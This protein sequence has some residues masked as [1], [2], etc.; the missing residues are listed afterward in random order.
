MG[1]HEARSWRERLVAHR[2]LA[3]SFPENTLA[4]VRGALE[5]GA[6]RVEIDVQLTEDQVPIVFHDA[7]LQR[8]CGVGGSVL[9]S[10]WSQLQKLRASEPGRFGTRF[11]DE[12]IAHL[13]DFAALVASFGAHA[14]VE[15]KGESLARFGDEA[16]LAAI[17]APLEQ[18]A[19]QCT[20]ISFEL[21]V[22]GLARERLPHPVG[23]VLK[24]WSDLERPELVQLEPEVVFVD[25]LKLPPGPVQALAPLCVYEVQLA[26][27]ARELVERG[28]ALIETFHVERL[29]AELE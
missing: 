16:M 26:Q 7:T 22:L 27:R 11:A 17:R 12:P 13:A 6:R 23:P 5:A 29:L 14:Y 4:S 25:D 28:V 1:F 9:S 2:G 15:L 20:L 3:A 8:L 21:P 24:E 18:L 19:G 10:H